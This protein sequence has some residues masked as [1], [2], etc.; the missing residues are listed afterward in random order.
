M[1][2]TSSATA[3]SIKDVQLGV[4][5]TSANAPAWIQQAK[6]V[7]KARH[8]WSVLDKAAREELEV[9]NAHYANSQ[10]EVSKRHRVTTCVYNSRDMPRSGQ[11]DV[12]CRRNVDT[13]GS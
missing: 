13:T 2:G 1:S 11:F 9:H 12:Q 4:H 5:L 10:L 6:H 8:Q 3:V 7:L